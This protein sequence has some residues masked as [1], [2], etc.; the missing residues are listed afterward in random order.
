MVQSSLV[1]PFYVYFCFHSQKV[2]TCTGITVCS[3][4]VEKIG[5]WEHS[6]SSWTCRNLAIRPGTDIERASRV[7]F[8][9]LNYSR[10]CQASPSVFYHD[11]GFTGDF[12]VK[13]QLKPPIPQSL[14]KNQLKESVLYQTWWNWSTQWKWLKKSI[15]FFTFRAKAS[16]QEF[17]NKTQKGLIQVRLNSC[18]MNC[19]C[20][21][22]VRLRF[23]CEKTP[24]EMS[25]VPPGAVGGSQSGSWFPH[26]CCCC[27]DDS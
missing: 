10:R 24:S 20:S 6:G 26:C 16:V 14:Q 3:V 7:L 22:L 19:C 9:H 15:K 18:E 25:N 2:G 21:D 8:P 4:Q 17:E 5:S 13:A 12:L 11:H 27:S 1:Q 23:R